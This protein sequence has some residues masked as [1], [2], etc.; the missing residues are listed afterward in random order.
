MG[1]L[2]GKINIPSGA[3]NAN[4]DSRLTRGACQADVKTQALGVAPGG[5]VAHG[6]ERGAVEVTGMESGAV[7]I[8][9][10]GEG[11]LV[12]LVAALAIVVLGKV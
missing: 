2:F 1:G 3:V 12:A 9:N 11:V 7:R 4:V 6:M 5:I 8:V 10:H